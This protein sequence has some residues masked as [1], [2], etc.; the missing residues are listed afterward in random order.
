MALS[1]VSHSRVE[2]S[3]SVNRKVTVPA[4]DGPGAAVLHHR[5]RKAIA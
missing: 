4:G 2:P 5:A 3:M 1:S